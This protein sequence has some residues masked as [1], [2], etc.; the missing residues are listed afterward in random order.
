[1]THP[2]TEEEL[3]GYT[4]LNLAGE[5]WGEYAWAGPATWC[6]IGQLQVGKDLI[7][8]QDKGQ[9]G[10]CI[11]IKPEPFSVKIL[12]NPWAEEGRIYL[13]H[14]GTQYLKYVNL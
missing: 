9:L 6:S 8:G 10:D 7:E 2:Q 3:I 12:M 1:M 5:S 14:A 13:A 11:W 4:W